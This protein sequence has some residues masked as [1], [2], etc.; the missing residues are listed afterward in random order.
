[1]NCLLKKRQRLIFGL[2]VLSGMIMSSCDTNDSPFS[3]AE[4]LLIQEMINQVSL[5]SL[6]D[7][8][9]T[10]VSFVTRNTYSD[11]LSETKGIGAARRW[12]Y[13]TFQE[14]SDANGGR[15]QVYYDTFEH[16]I[17]EHLQ[18]HFGLEEY[19]MRNVVALLP[20]K[21]DDLR[22]I[23][24]G[25]Y[26]S[27]PSEDLTPENLNDPAPG[28]DDDGSGTVITMELARVLSA[29][30]FDHTILFVAFVA[31]EQGLWGADHMAQTAL[32]EEWDV[33]AV[34]GN[35]IVGN[36][37]GGNGVT[38]D[39]YVRVFS[40]DPVDSKSRN[41]A[42]YIQQTGGPYVPELDVRLVFRLDRFGRG[43]DHSRFVR[44]GYAGV[45]FSE[46]YENYA[47]QH[48]EHDK[49]EYTSREYMTN[50]AK[51]QTAVLATAANAPRKVWM[52]TPSRDR[53]TYQTIIRWTHET[54]EDDIAGYK[55]YI[56]P[57]DTGYWQEIRD[58][59]IPEW[60][61]YAIGED[62]DRD[63]PQG[64]EVKFDYRSID[65]Y[66]FG[67]SSYDRDGNES[68]V[69]TVENPSR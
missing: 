22:Y 10:L 56:R 34:I 35:D 66:V 52:L 4:D 24:N 64:Y 58:V 14:Y 42:R 33:A 51:I 38:E 26:D 28:A 2:F 11:T 49:A 16:V 44:R 23:V 6:T 45:R 21:T 60:I 37:H 62:D 19:P 55:I 7:L 46:P 12:I 63:I 20:G 18:E 8:H 61:D 57:T 53:E 9:D 13:N 50:V 39:R 5:D 36:I 25:H 40:P 65:D 17:P 69:A 15:L 1:M 41:W 68:V 30:E 3:T 48:N 27:S 54:D 29:Y 31:E 43:G 59:G 67:V 47:Y 32:D